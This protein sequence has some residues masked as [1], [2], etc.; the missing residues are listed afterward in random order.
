MRFLHKWQGAYNAILNMSGVVYMFVSSPKILQVF[1]SPRLFK[2][3][4]LIFFH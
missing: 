4:V 1:V 3:Y 2:L